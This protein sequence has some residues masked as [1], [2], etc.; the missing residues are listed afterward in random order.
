MRQSQRLPAINL[1]L[2][3]IRQHTN[4]AIFF[5]RIIAL[6]LMQDGQQIF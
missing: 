6:R 5:N 3:Q 4:P 1:A 2:H